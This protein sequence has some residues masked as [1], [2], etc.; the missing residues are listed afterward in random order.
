MRSLPSSASAMS[1]R[2]G[3]RR[4]HGGRLD[5]RERQ[6]EGDRQDDADAQHDAPVGDRVDGRAGGEQ[7]RHQGDERRGR[8]ATGRSQSA[9][10]APAPSAPPPLAPDRDR[11]RQQ[12]QHRSRPRACAHGRHALEHR[13]ELGLALPED[14]LACRQRLGQAVR[15]LELVLGRRV[16]ARGGEDGAHSSGSDRRGLAY[17]VPRRSSAMIA[18]FL[19]QRDLVRVGASSARR[20]SRCPSSSRT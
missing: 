13:H 14:P 12:H 7:P 20:R 16:V 9:A 18:L 19:E 8:S 17:S 1:P 3:A 10:T 11:P 15:R 2:A 4:P 5:A 6:V